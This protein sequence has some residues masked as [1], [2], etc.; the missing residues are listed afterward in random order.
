MAVL[1]NAGGVYDRASIPLATR[2]RTHI[3][4]EQRPEWLPQRMRVA[5]E[6]MKTVRPEARLRSATAI[7]NC[8]GMV[9]AA[10]RTWIDTGDVPLILREDSYRLVERESDV[11]PGDLVVYRTVPGEEVAHIGVV[12]EARAD[13]A[14]AYMRFMVLSKW[15]SEGEYVHPIDHVPPSFGKPVEFWAE[16]IIL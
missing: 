11:V 6:N 16:R 9:F 12:I 13:V 1:I 15:G 2:K 10:R 4:N 5:I 7:Y 8:V 3:R 14:S